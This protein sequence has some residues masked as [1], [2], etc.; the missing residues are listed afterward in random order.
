MEQMMSKRTAAIILVAFLSTQLAAEVYILGGRAVSR[1]SVLNLTGVVSLKPLHTER[2]VV[3]SS[4]LSLEVYSFN[5][6]FFQLAEKLKQ[7]RDSRVISANGMIRCRTELP[8]K[9]IEHLLFI[10]SGKGR[11]IIAFRLLFEP[12]FSGNR[13]WHP[14]LPD[15]PGGAKSE[16]VLELPDRKAVFALFNNA[17]GSAQGNLRAVLSNLSNDWHITADESVMPKSRGAMLIGKKNAV[18]LVGFSDDGT[19]F[20]YVKKG[21]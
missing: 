4:D 18:M 15:L 21:Q 5:G 17:F 13:N 11:Q 10:N 1:Q 2:V 12:G 16:L 20:F 14:D 6:D 19:G 9:H 3:G 7:N 8:E